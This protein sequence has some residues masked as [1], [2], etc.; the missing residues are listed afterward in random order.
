ME[1]LQIENFLGLKIPSMEIS[2]IT[3]FIGPQASGKSVCAKLIYFFRSIGKE[4]Y[5]SMEAKETKYDLDNKLAYRFEE[6]FPPA[7]IGTN[8]FSIHYT[9][10]NVEMTVSKTESKQSR[11]KL[12]YSSEFVKK[13]NRGKIFIKKTEEKSIDPEKY[14]EFEMRYDRREHLYELIK[15][16]FP[17]TILYQQLFIPAGRSFFANL[18]SGIFTFLS[19][20]NA[21][22]PFLR[23][24]GSYYE[25][26]KSR[27]HLKRNTPI[28]LKSTFDQIEKLTTTVLRGKYMREKNKDF[29]Q[30][31]DG[32]KINLANCS[33]GQQE[34]LPLSMILSS[35]PLARYI[36][37][38]INVYIEEPEAHLFPV[39]QK[40]VVDLLGCIF[41]NSQSAV[42][43]V[44]TT[45]S[46]Y[47][48]SS[49]NLL[50]QKGNSLKNEKVQ[51]R[52]M[53]D[54]KIDAKNAF[55]IKDVAAFSLSDGRLKN[56]ISKEN[57]LIDTNII[58]D[59]SNEINN[60]F[61]KL[62]DVE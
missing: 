24:F 61:I 9:N 46:P 39:A 31:N 60:E 45:H 28:K 15:S 18:Q 2:R 58:D 47:I 38:G 25:S 52:K 51:K 54:I 43:Y 57:E 32:R 11:I 10:E 34:A 59:I 22:D 49:M 1:Y 8:S 23:D 20:S 42:R 48:L 62:L 14:D 56:L 17:N 33:S 40:Q 19:N 41:N 55:D 37:G 7:S 13:L 36:G 50:I 27:A 5:E 21:L 30:L 3:I 44:I 26:I 12:N 35:I 53:E 4:V 16:D 6:Y 29:I